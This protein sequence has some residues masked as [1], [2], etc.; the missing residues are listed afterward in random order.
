VL[1][2]L[3]R[4]SQ[5]QPPQD[6]ILTPVWCTLLPCMNRL[7]PTFH[8]ITIFVFI[9]EIFKLLL[10]SEINSLLFEVYYN[11]LCSSNVSRSN[12]SNDLYPVNQED[13]T[14]LCDSIINKCANACYIIARLI[15]LQM[16]H[17]IE[18]EIICHCILLNTPHTKNVSD[19]TYRPQWDLH[20]ILCTIFCTMNHFWEN[21]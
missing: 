3:W 20:F 5:A 17:S 9:L 6:L 19:I 4:L 18:S 14:T 10:M 11:T 12:N 2:L 1:S 7:Q 13:I 15:T 21:W 8:N 16:S